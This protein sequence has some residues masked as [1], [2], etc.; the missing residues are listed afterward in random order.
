MRKGAVR[1]ACQTD[2]RGEMAEWSKAPGW[3]PGAP[4]GAREFESRSLRHSLNGGR[5]VV[6]RIAD[7]DSAGVGSNP[8]G[9]PKF[10]VIGA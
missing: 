4:S 2:L 1:R 6:V 3:K 7:C 10:V 5:G 9:H 8:T